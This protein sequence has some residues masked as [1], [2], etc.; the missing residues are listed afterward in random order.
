MRCAEVGENEVVRMTIYT[1]NQKTVT[2][3]LKRI[4]V[5]NI[6]IALRSC[7]KLTETNKWNELHQIVFDQLKEHDAKQRGAER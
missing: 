5:C 3:K 2:L 4:D 6:L 1:E 7:D